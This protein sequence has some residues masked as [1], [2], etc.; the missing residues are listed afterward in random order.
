[1]FLCNLKLRSS[2]T[3]SL[4]TKILKLILSDVSMLIICSKEFYH[5]TNAKAKRAENIKNIKRDNSFIWQRSFF[6]DKGVSNFDTKNKVFLFNQRIQKILLNFTS[7]FFH[8]I[9]IKL[10]YL[11]TK[12]RINSKFKYLINQKKKNML[13]TSIISKITKAVN[14]LN[15][16]SRFGTN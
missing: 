1:M 4:A 11:M 3:E 14:P 8:F 12:I 6:Y 7:I 10:L 5:L 2:R 13:C 15:Y 16:F 9:P